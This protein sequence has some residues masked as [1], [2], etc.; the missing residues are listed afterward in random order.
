[1][2]KKMISVAVISLVV[3][4]TSGLTYALTDIRPLFSVAVTFGTIFYHL[5][6]RLTIGG[7]IDAKYHNH[8]DYTKKW[9][10]ERAFEKKLY[11][12]LKV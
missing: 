4:V 8:M 2:K 10:R 9:F 12:A 11:Q 1:M 3:L 7:L 5:A 6:M